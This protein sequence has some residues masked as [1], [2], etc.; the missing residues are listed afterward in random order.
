MTSRFSDDLDLV[1]P[2]DYVPTRSA[3]RGHYPAPRICRILNNFL[4]NAKGFHA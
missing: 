2:E 1:A 4:Q 3:N